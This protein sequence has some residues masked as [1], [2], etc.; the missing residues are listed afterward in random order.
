M[1]Q[2]YDL[3]DANLLLAALQKTHTNFVP[4]LMEQKLNASYLTAESIRNGEFKLRRSCD[5][6]VKLLFSTTLGE[7]SDKQGE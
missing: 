2:A 3:G 5:V 1:K 6:L 4:G 7:I